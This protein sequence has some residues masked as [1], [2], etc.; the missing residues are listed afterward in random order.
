MKIKEM[1]S[2]SLH[3]LHVRHNMTEPTHYSLTLQL[4]QH[5]VISLFK[6]FGR[7]APTHLTMKVYDKRADY[8]WRLYLETVP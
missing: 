4:R 3:P 7:V 2:S 1:F 6:P 8:E 5:S